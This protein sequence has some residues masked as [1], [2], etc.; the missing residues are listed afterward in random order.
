M[1]AV[2]ATP[3]SGMGSSKL[4]DPGHD[5]LFM[6]LPYNPTAANPLTRKAAA[7]GAVMK[8]HS[9]TMIAALSPVCKAV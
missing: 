4:Q 1:V 6:N 8:V 9:P 5:A 2:S 3:F 7:S